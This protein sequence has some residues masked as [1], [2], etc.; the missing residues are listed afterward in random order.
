[1][2]GI[3]RLV[4]LAG[5][6]AT[7]VLLFAAPVWAAEEQTHLFSAAKSLTGGCKTSASDPIPDPGPCPGTPGVDHPPKPF[8]GGETGVV[9]D[10]Y[11]DI[12]VSSFPPETEGQA[13]RVDIFNPE[14][15]FLY[16]L[17]APGVQHIAVGP[18]GFLYADLRNGSVER[19]DPTTYDPEHSK[20]AY[21]SP[22]VIIP[23]PDP[24]RNWGTGIGIAVDPSNG[25]LYLPYERFGARIVELGPP[26]PGEPNAILAEH[27]GQGN[28]GGPRFV[29]VDATHE[30]LYV[31]TNDSVI[32]VFEQ[33]GEHELLETID[34]ST[35]PGNTKHFLSGEN[36]LPVAA[37]EETGHVFV[38]DIRSGKTVY[39][40][41][42]DGSYIW[43]VSQPK[44]EGF[45]NIAIDNSSSSPNH[46]YL[47]MNSIINGVESMYAFEPYSPPAAPVV[48]SLF[49]DGVGEHVAVLHAVVDPEGEETHYLFEYT[50]QQRFEVEGFEGATVAGE[51]TLPP[52]RDGK[53]VSAPATGLA[54]GGKYRFRVVASNTCEP[55]G[56]EGE[57]QSTFAT[58][59]HYPSSG[60]CPNDEL[61]IGLSV[62][63]PDC[64]AYELVTPTDTKGRPPLPFGG[65]FRARFGSPTVSPQGEVVAFGISGGALPIGNG[66]GSLDIYLARRGG[67]GWES[68]ASGISGDQASEALSAGISA[69]Q[70]YTVWTSGRLGP[71]AIEGKNTAYLRRPDGS[72]QLIGEGSLG[73]DPEI[74]PLYLA[75]GA[76]HTVFSTHEK[77]AV[78]LE[79]Q[80]P[81]AGTRTIYDRTP[82]G[83]THV[84]S[85]FPGDA[86]PAAGQHSFYVS[87]SDD[88]SSVVFQLSEN[89]SAP[90]YLRVEDEETLEAAAQALSGRQL[91][92]NPGS[93]LAGA[94]PSYEWLLDGSPIPGATASTYTPQAEQA[95]SL[96]Q[97]VVRAG[98]SEGASV[99]ASVP[100]AIDHPHVGG[101]LPRPG[102]ITISSEQLV[103]G[104]IVECE[105][106]G[107]SPNP[108]PSLQWYRNGSPIPG[109]TSAAY[110]VQPADQHALLQCGAIAEANG[111]SA[112]AFSRPVEIA[113]PE[114]PSGG[115]TLENLTHPGLAPVL[116]DQLKC[117]A[118]GWSGKPSFTYQWLRNGT[119]IASATSATYTVAAADEGTAL[120]C[121]VSGA[122]ST[123]TTAAV[124]SATPVVPLGA[125][126]VPAGGLIVKGPRAVGSS[127]ECEASGWSGEPS[128]TYQWLRNGTPIASAT[129]ATYTL[130]A[131]DREKMVQCELTAAGAE[132]SAVALAGGFINEK[133]RA[134]AQTPALQASLAGLSADGRY[135]YYLLAGD[136]YR[137]DTQTQETARVTETGDARPV[138][139]PS[140]GEGVYFLSKTALG[141]GPNPQG[142]EPQPLGENLY[143]WDGSQ[144]RFLGT[145]TERDAKGRSLFGP[146]VDGLEN[147]S[148][149][150]AA[151]E[152]AIDPARSTPDGS[153][154]AFESRADLVGVEPSGHAQVYLYDAAASTLT[155]ITCNP[156][157]SPAS[158]DAS[159]M[160]L[161]EGFGGFL[162]G[163]HG[164]A[165]LVSNLSPDGRRVFFES[166]E[167]LVPEDNDGVKDV[168]EWE[169]EG[170]GTCL[171]PG[172]CLFLISSGQS[173]NPNYLFGVSESG[174]DV[175]IET[176]DLLVADDTDAAESIYDVRVGGGFPPDAATAGE[177]LGEACQPAATAP[178]APVQELQGQG[179][180][181][182]P[183]VGKC[184]KGQHRVSR[185]GKSR[186]VG[187]KRKRRKHHC[188]KP[189]RF[190]TRGSSSRCAS[191]TSRHG[192]DLA[193]GGVK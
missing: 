120:Q 138:L 62:G 121:K 20:I 78:Q 17:P 67:G 157:G 123:A 52:G 38:G 104:Q 22:P 40:F 3:T 60:A 68:V 51:G 23:S 179:N 73:S 105:V 94:T 170:K 93:S 15:K 181:M 85:L 84:I 64:R 184:R 154:L 108:N 178:A 145:V 32:K 10:A 111:A 128:F 134:S 132:A 144:V 131:T 158:S 151:H 80:A 99:A 191:H 90:L 75:P 183:P 81:A 5:C 117:E 167:R 161:N 137:F 29:A 142:A 24:L 187:H 140:S 186:C 155:C 115:A 42:A 69:D 2:S 21:E 19:F 28:L 77:T 97:C 98:N 58:F 37:D 168:Y 112:P 7:F 166:N 91:S 48:E 125:A 46:G 87:S 135:L 54:A 107:W 180:Y 106:S 4:K 156:T 113:P 18:S 127:L 103:V 61:R 55:G 185:G 110:E 13:A 163:I 89:K 63:L 177:C 1:M 31:S 8:A 147:W 124:S 118:S 152:T 44:M 30:R 153:T 26:A 41:G 143:Y 65:S 141:T 116:A 126:E 159:L 35:L 95:G 109:A 49:V 53:S 74:E 165:S 47:F 56:C 88:G 150:V 171:E 192:R 34:G 39:E 188:R 119:P 174:D 173:S 72:L 27:I 122:N 9:T 133:P 79:P 162:N 130:T 45:G 86:A 96:L 139:V 190:G 83:A 102:R 101:P 82:D 176:N 149:R 169:A 36:R 70:R 175:F 172:G 114:A 164:G 66:T 6:A 12:Y 100:L 92:C 136:L 71:L 57:A 189:S 33:H 25:H 50:T 129:S 14:G 148:E 76:A 160:S 146:F 11:G 182:K 193:T 43:S 59:P 16:E